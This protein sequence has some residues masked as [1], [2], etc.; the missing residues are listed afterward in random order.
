VWVGFDTPTSLGDRQSAATVALPIWMQFMVKAL[1]YFPDREFPA[2]AGVT[3]ARVDPATGKAVP[4]GSSEGL[5]LPFRLGTVPE[6]AAPAG[7]P[8]APRRGATDDLL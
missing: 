1:A 4:P 3:S 5:V 8:A 7:K 6:V 2:P